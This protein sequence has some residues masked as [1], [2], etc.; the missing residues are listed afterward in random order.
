MTTT[1]TYV[2]QEGRSLPVFVY[3]TDSPRVNID[4]LLH[5]PYVVAYPSRPGDDED[6]KRRGEAALI[7]RRRA[8]FRFIVVVVVCCCGRIM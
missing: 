3:I 1:T 8:M 2:F 4:T 7:L 5:H 6:K